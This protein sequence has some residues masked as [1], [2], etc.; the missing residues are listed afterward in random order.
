M[1][2]D[3]RLLARIERGQHR[4]QVR[5]AAHA[6]EDG[7][8]VALVVQLAGD[9]RAD[10]R[11]HLGVDA[12]R[13]LIDHQQ[14]HVELAQLARDRAEG[15]LSRGVGVQELVGFLDGD[16]QRPRPVGFVLGVPVAL[17]LLDPQ[18]VQPPGDDVGGQDVR[19]QVALATELQHDVLAA[20][21][22]GDHLVE[23]RAFEGALDERQPVD[24]AAAC[25]A[26]R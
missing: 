2:Q 21:E 23:R 8:D 9:A 12:A 22:L 16:H 3:Q 1:A 4:A 6:G 19:Q 7:V 14:R 5:T 11:Q 15:R 10:L 26:A 18:L 25:C 20:F 13:P 24:Q 17:G